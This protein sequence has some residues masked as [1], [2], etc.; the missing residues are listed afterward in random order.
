MS[1]N[2]GKVGAY[3]RQTEI[4]QFLKKFEKP[5]DMKDDA[6]DT[7]TMAENYPHG[8]IPL[9][10]ISQ[11]IDIVLGPN[12]RPKV[13][14][15]DP[16]L[17]GYLH[18][19]WYLW[20]QLYL[21]PRF[22]RDVAPNHIFKIEGDWD[23][24]CPIVPCAIRVTIDGVVYVF[25]WD[26]H[27][28]V[29]NMKRQG[30]TKFPVWF[31]D[32]DKMIEDGVEVPEEFDDIVEFAVNKAGTNMVRINSRNKRKLSAYDEFMILLEV[33]DS[34]TVSMNNILS[35]TGYLPKRHPVEGGFTQ[36]KSGQTIFEM[37]DDYGTKGKYF[38]RAL[39]FQKRTWPMAPAELEVWRPMALLYKQCEIE[40][41]TLDE[42]FDIELGEKLVELY[43]D[44]SSTQEALKELYYDALH[45]QGFTE[46][47]IHDQWRVYDALISVYKK[48]IGR[49]DLPQAQCR[50]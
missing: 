12:K 43:G 9:E 25:I 47:R 50:F 18:F 33:K 1:K 36:I 23:D 42:Q 5:F 48:E 28:T 20:N 17:Q 44:P 32:V 26:G 8:I 30:Y 24:T 15:F 7:R 49:L 27:H 34:A 39:A 2:T 45:E 29:Q 37:T 3:N 4:K 31:L 16:E 13:R 38:K 41:F 11:A 22:Q 40:G 14:T 21:W 19:D 35:A 6:I 10:D 46:P